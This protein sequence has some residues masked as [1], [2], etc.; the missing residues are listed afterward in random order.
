[1]R[2]REQ[3]ASNRH[4]HVSGDESGNEYTPCALSSAYSRRAKRVDGMTTEQ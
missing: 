3:I 4:R 2:A 1:M